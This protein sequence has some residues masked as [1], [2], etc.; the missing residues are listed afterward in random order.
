MILD[1]AI[2]ILLGTYFNGGESINYLLIIMA[3]LFCLL[4]DIDI[5]YF[6]YQKYIKKTGI[7]DHRSWTHYPIVY[8]PIYFLIMSLELFFTTSHTISSIFALAIVWHFVHDTL[9]IGWGVMWGFPF[10]KRKYKIFPDRNG[11]VTSK[12]LLSWLPEEEADIIKWS[13]GSLDGWLRHYYFKFNIVSALEYG[14]FVL[15]LV[16]VYFKYFML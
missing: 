8:L 11:K 13:G 2:G 3:V 14:V 12:V 6:L 4:P 9:F 1:I 7:I 15:V 5:F 16:Y 10:S